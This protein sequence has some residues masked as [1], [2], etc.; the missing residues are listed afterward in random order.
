MSVN[1][2]NKKML[3]YVFYPYT[4]PK[5]PREFFSKELPQPACDECPV[6][7]Q[8]ETARQYARFMGRRH[9]ILETYID[10]LHIEGK[11]QMLSIKTSVLSPSHTPGYYLAHSDQDIFYP[12]PAM[13]RQRN[14]SSEPA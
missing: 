2:N 7:L 3:V 9:I 1:S 13:I 8:L 12:N 14:K 5:N 6:F 11:S 10:E 4:K